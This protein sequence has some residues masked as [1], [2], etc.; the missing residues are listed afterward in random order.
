MLKPL[1]CLIH[2]SR[3]KQVIAGGRIDFGGDQMWMSPWLSNHYKAKLVLAENLSKV[4]MVRPEKKCRHSTSGVLPFLY[5]AIT[6]RL[7]KGHCTFSWWRG[8]AQS[9]TQDIWDVDYFETS[10]S[11]Y[12]FPGFTFLASSRWIGEKVI[13]DSRSRID[14]YLRWALRLI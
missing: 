11:R 2:W 6:L 14:C 10:G 13:L 12:T 3:S 4:C 8:Q 1:L 7:S 9:W 5:Q